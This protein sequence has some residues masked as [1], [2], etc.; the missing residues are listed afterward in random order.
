MA[1]W[2]EAFDQIRKQERRIIEAQR[3]F[4][5]VL[6][7]RFSRQSSIAGPAIGKFKIHR[8]NRGD[9]LEKRKADKIKNGVVGRIGKKAPTTPRLKL[10]QA[11]IKRIIF[12][13][14]FYLNLL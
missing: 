2:I 8:W 1:R 4:A 12:T 11:I 13:E 5:L 9:D 14:Y 10:I 6:M 7:T 3:I